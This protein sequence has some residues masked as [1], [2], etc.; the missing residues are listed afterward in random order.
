MTA[1]CTDELKELALQIIADD[2]NIG[3]CARRCGIA[4]ST[5][6]AWRR[7][8]ALFADRFSEALEDGVDRLEHLAQIRAFHGVEEPVFYKGVEVG[9][10]TRYS[11]SLAALLLKAHRPERFRERSEVNQNLNGTLNLSNTDRAARLAAIL[12]A[13]QG[14]MVIPLPVNEAITGEVQAPTPAPAPAPEP[15]L[16]GYEDLI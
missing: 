8:D 12:A 14:R 6:D 4:R 5:L 2:P 7:D 1:H 9:T 15:E 13:A 10:V 16:L 11:D 3:N